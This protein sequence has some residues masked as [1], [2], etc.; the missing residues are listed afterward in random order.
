MGYSLRVLRPSDRALYLLAGLCLLTPLD[1]FGVG[2]WI[3]GL[4]AAI[5]VSL[6]LRERV[7]RRRAA[8]AT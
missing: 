3:N 6:L 7:L 5:A 2:R 8:V 1:A 4:G